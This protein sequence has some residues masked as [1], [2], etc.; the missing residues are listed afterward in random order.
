M[1]S[2]SFVNK[3]D[4]ITIY[5][6]KASEKIS[7]HQHD[8]DHETIFVKGVFIYKEADKE[9]K[10]FVGA[11]NPESILSLKGVS[12]EIECEL[13]PCILCSINKEL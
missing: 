4:R 6:L 1:T 8:W 3:G 5:S 13:G 12:H 11:E 10:K 9:D 2:H 7:W